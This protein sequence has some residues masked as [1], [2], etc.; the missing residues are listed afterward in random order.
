MYSYGVKYILYPKSLY[1][2]R[3]YTYC[4]K[5]DFLLIFLGLSFG[6]IA[7]GFL[8]SK[9]WNHVP[10]SRLK[11]VLSMGGSML[12]VCFLVKV[13]LHVSRNSRPGF[14][15]LW[16]FSLNLSQLGVMGS[17]RGM[18]SLSVVLVRVLKSVLRSFWFC[19]WVITSS[20]VLIRR[21][22]LSH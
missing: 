19:T 18:I 13:Y 3:Y 7:Y 2:E 21:S 5:K 12:N 15:H 9:I 14:S 6:F 4:L 1:L 20:T 16:S 10:C 8:C 11:F 22:R 17:G